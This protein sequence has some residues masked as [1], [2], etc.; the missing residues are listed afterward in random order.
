MTEHGPT[1]PTWLCS[2]CGAP[3]PCAIR[4]L[5]LL[6]EYRFAPVSLAYYMSLCLMDAAQDMSWAPPMSLHRRFLGWVAPKY[7]RRVIRRSI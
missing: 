7:P 5:Q 4:R 3:W 6:Q 1:K 2:G